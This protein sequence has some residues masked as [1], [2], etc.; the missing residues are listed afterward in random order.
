MSDVSSEKKYRFTALPA[1]ASL[2]NKPDSSDIKLVINDLSFYAHTNLL[3]A[4]SDVFTA[5]LGPHWMPSSDAASPAELVLN[6]DA[7]SVRVFDR[8]LYFI[9][10]G[11]VV[12]TDAYV[13]PLFVLADKY[14]VKVLYDECAKIIQTGLKV[15]KTVSNNPKSG[16][17][18]RWPNRYMTSSD[19]TDSS[20]SSDFDD[21]DGRIASIVTEPVNC[22]ASVNVNNSDAVPMTTSRI[23]L[24]PSEIFPVTLVL[25]LLRYGHNAEIHRAALLNLE[26]RVGNQ[27]S[28]GYYPAIWNDLR[29]DVIVDILSDSQF[30]YPEMFLFDAAKVWLQARSERVSDE[31]TVSSVLECI[32][33]PLLTVSELYRV[34]S[35][36]LIVGKTRE[37]VAQAIRYKLFRD[38]AASEREKWTGIQFEKR[39][40]Q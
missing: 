12:I 10:S 13:V 29:V 20:D 1:S 27:I 15:F 3:C 25:R 40:S 35:D 36:P 8:F 31:T 28:L 17:V 9:Y 34:D 16:S 33:F 19:S 37:L 7:E 39:F 4:A 24:I 30:C 18:S 26:A 32:R 5:M 21:Y 6:E 2:Y 38:C 14:N 11:N 22:S 23:R